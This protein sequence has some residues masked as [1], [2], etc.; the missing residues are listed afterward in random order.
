MAVRFLTKEEELFYGRQVQEM[1]KAKDVL[2]RKNF[3]DKKESED[4][5]RIVQ[6]GEKALEIMVRANERLVYKQAIKFK[7]SFKG[8]PPLED[9]IQEGMVGLVT[10]IMRYDPSRGNKLS[11]MAT[12]WIFQNICRQCNSFS[13]TVRLPENRVME[14]TKINQIKKD[15]MDND[16]MSEHEADEVVMRD[17]K[18]DKKVYYSIVNAGST[19]ASL[20]ASVDSEVELGDVIDLHSDDRVED[21]ALEKISRDRI[22]HALELLDPIE[23]DVIGA[24]FGFP[25]CSGR[26]FTVKDVRD[27]YSIS[28]FVFKS[29]TNRAL[30][31]LRESLLSFQTEHFS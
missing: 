8:A 29:T 18:L 9:I 31:K 27:K 3:S 26:Y 23:K 22:A 19:V 2:S 11:T 15:L 10:A 30:K 6:E 13:R 20:N 25:D 21:M 1:R 17:L 28:H 7:K 5:Y 24:S 12:Y 14:L 4:L 16:G